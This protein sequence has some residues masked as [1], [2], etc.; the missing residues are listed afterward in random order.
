MTRPTLDFPPIMWG[1]AVVI[2]VG[3]YWGPQTIT[4]V[5]TALQVAAHLHILGIGRP[6]PTSPQP[7]GPEQEHPQ[8]RGVE[9]GGRS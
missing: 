5:V 6:H 1:V 8:H 2:A 3:G 9:T 4:L 7:E